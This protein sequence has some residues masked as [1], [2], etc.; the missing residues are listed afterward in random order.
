MY[1]CSHSSSCGGCSE[2]NKNYQKQLLSKKELLKSLFSSSKIDISDIV[3]SP[4]PYYYRHKVQLPFGFDRKQGGLILGCYSND[5][6]SV[7]NQLECFIQDRDLSGVVFGIREWAKKHNLS[8]YNER[9]GSGLLRHV[10]LRKGAGTGEILIGL[11]MNGDR[12]EG[13]RFL[14]RKLIDAVERYISEK[15]VIAGIIQN[16]NTRKTNVVLGEKELCWWGRPYIK[17]VMGS[18]NFKVGLSTFFQVNPFQTPNLYNEVLRWIP[19]GADVLDLYSGTGSIALWIT[20]RAHEVVGIEE[21]K[22]S[23]SAARAAAALNKRRNVRFIAGDTAA[24]LPEL[25]SRGYSVAVI[26]PPRKGIEK[27]VAETILSSSLNRLIYVSCNPQSLAR[28]IDEL[29]QKFRLVSL[30]GFD[31]FPHTD[32]IESVAVLDR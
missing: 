12:V 14:S 18:L 32:H 25:S 8:S 6:H 30:Q 20:S 9:T 21:N 1:H 26:D 23:V 19:E 3:P 4:Q 24:M 17:E 11:V 10:L 27:S 16:V 5:S 28:D 2:L 13:T 15:C 31:M 22:A 7:I 29:K